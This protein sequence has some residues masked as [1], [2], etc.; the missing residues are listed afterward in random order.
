MQQA[1]HFVIP[2]NICKVVKDKANLRALVR[3]DATECSSLIYLKE[4]INRAQDNGY[5]P[6]SLEIGIV[7]PKV[8]SSII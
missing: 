1:R 2:G 5:V 4:G 7:M 8:E 3:K 6:V